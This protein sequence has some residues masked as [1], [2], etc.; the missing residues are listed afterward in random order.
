M[1]GLG[2]TAVILLCLGTACVIEGAVIMWSDK[3][4]DNDRTNGL[5]T[6]GFGA[7]LFLGGAGALI[8]SAE[9]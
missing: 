9:T 4:D 3:T 2:W 6:A 1:F 5:V 7:A 8:G